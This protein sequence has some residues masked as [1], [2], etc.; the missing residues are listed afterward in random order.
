MNLRPVKVSVEQYDAILR[1]HQLMP[2]QLSNNPVALS[3]SHAGC[4]RFW[5]IEAGRRIIGLAIISDV[6]PGD[7]CSLHVL[8]ESSK[9]RYMRPERV[10]MRSRSVYHARGKLDAF[11]A[12]L[13]YCFEEL[14]VERINIAI[15]SRRRAAVRLARRL[16]I[17]EEGCVR[18][19]VSLRGVRDD[20]ILFGILKGDY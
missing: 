14:G 9:R 3:F 11:S 1:S 5:V 18:S 10:Q 6:V 19:A 8:V 2:D 4:H 16:G 20:V 12:V 13:D 15:P 7:S 17:R